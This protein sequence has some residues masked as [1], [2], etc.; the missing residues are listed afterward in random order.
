MEK[1]TKG[2]SRIAMDKIKI[3]N[4]SKMKE[5]RKHVRTVDLIDQLKENVWE[6]YTRTKG[7]D[8]PNW[9]DGLSP[10]EIAAFKVKFKEVQEKTP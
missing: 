7:G 2:L 5:I 4:K 9:I 1:D 3:M 10:I 6:E 8:Y